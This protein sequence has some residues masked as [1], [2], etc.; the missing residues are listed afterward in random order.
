M[1]ADRTGVVTDGF[2]LVNLPDIYLQKQCLDWILKC[3]HV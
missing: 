2:Y 1:S 3:E